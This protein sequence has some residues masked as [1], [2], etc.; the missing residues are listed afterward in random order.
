MLVSG[1]RAD[2]KDRR[3]ALPDVQPLRLGSLELA[4]H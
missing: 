3:S 1:H 2:G 4:I